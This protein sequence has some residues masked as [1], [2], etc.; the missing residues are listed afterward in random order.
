MSSW[1]FEPFTVH[2]NRST[3]LESIFR[4]ASASEQFSLSKLAA[5]RLK[6]SHFFLYLLIEN[7]SKRPG[8]SRGGKLKSHMWFIL[9]WVCSAKDY[10][11]HQNVVKTSLTHSPLA[12]ALLL[13]FYHNV[14]SSVIYYWVELVSLSELISWVDRSA[15]VVISLLCGQAY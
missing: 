7:P 5:E 11:R 6:D 15:W 10:R 2:L 4:T 9:P 8:T 3:R 14:M 13:C 1:Y 12:H